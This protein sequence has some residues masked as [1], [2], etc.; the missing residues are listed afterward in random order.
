M[1]PTTGAVN[2]GFGEFCSEGAN[3]AVRPQHIRLR[4]ADSRRCPSRQWRKS[5]ALHRATESHSLPGMTLSL[6]S[7]DKNPAPWPVFIGETVH[8]CGGWQ[9]HPLGPRRRTGEQAR[10]PDLSRPS[11]MLDGIRARA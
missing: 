3:P 2:V 6:A 7:P 5:A 9:V 8:T 1:E 4:V 10:V 11:S